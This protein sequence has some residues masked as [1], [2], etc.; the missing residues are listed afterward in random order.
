MDSNTASAV[1][2]QLNAPEPVVTPSEPASSTPAAA[3]PAAA[4]T[5]PF[6]KVNDRT[7]YNS[8][9]DAIKG[10]NELQGRVTSLSAWEAMISAPIEKGGFGLTDPKQVAALLDELADI[11]AK[12]NQSATP[13]ANAPGSTAAAVQKAAAGDRIAYESLSPEWKAHVDYLKQLGYVTS[14]ALKPLQEQVQSLSEAQEAAYAAEVNNAVSHG[15]SIL[16]GVMKETGIAITP[17]LLEQVGNSVGSRIDR[18]SYDQNGRIIPNS[19]ADQFLR[20]NEAERK[21]IITK[22]FDLFLQF[23]NAFSTAKTASYVANKNAAQSGQPRALPQGS[24][25][26]STPRTGRM[27][28][29]Q[30]KAALSEAL[31]AG[32]FK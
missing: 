31:S 21:A 9:D 16:E 12:Q 8:A 30:R 24:P 10:Y 7:S 29:D 13:T 1:A 4:A 2:E 32:G 11:R 22:E 15:T 5:P 27:T 28:E 20:G 6:L 25:P 14:D 17:E 19:L 3:P 18:D 23:G 26:A